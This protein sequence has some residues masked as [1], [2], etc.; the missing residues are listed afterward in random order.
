[1]AKKTI[2]DRLVEALLARGCKKIEN[3]RT[4]KYTVIAQNDQN[5]TSFYFV[6]PSGAL[7]IGRIASKT[8]PVSEKFKKN[9]LDGVA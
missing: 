5:D 1:M 6:G 8:I 3:A 4:T 9:L 2:H 7:R